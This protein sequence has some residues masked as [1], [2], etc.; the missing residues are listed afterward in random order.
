MKNF[1]VTWVCLVL[2]GLCLLGT[3]CGPKPAM[4]LP[5]SYL[6]PRQSMTIEIKECPKDANLPEVGGGLLTMGTIAVRR[7]NNR[8]LLGDISGDTLRNA[9]KQE[10]EERFK[11]HFDM[12]N[13]QAPLVA[14]AEISH[15]GLNSASTFFGIGTSGKF[16]E[17]R[18]TV[19]VFDRASQQRKEIGYVA[20]WGSSAD[21]GDEP[22]P[23]QVRNALTKAIDGLGKVVADSLVKAGSPAIASP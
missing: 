22:A 15:W 2:A 3:G 1:G 6:T 18:A 14:E 11:T 16:F 17:V 8:K 21:L 4:A 7:E 19:S 20:A 13:G 10:L 23:K 5:S 12:A 9:L